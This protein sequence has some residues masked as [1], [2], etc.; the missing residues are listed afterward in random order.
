MEKLLS[1]VAEA[2]TPKNKERDNLRKFANKVVKLIN[3]HG[4]AA[5]IEGSLAKDTWISGNHDI[6]IFVFFEKST[7][8]ELFEKE[9]VE[10]GKK[11]IKELGG[12]AELAYS[13]HP[14]TRAQIKGVNLD[15]VPAYRLERV[16]DR[17]SAVDRTPFHTKYVSEH[18]TQYQKREVR[19]LKQFTKG[20][21]VYSAKEKVRG[22]SGYLC[23]LLVLNYGSLKGVA[24]AAVN[25]W[26]YGLV[27]DLEK[28]HKNRRDAFKKFQDALI[29]IDPTDMN[30]NVAAALDENNFEIFI[31]AF[32]NFLKKPTIQFFF[33]NLVEPYSET[34]LAQEMAKHG[35]I[36]I[37][38][39]K[40]P[41]IQED[42]LYSQLRKTRKNLRK[43]FEHFDFKVVQT[44]AL[45]NEETYIVIELENTTLPEIKLLEGPPIK[46]DKKYQDAFVEKY[47]KLKPWVKNKRWQVNV[48]RRYTRAED[49]FK[50]VINEPEKHG[51]PKYVIKSMSKK[52]TILTGATI[53]NEYTGEFARFLTRYLSNK[54]PWEW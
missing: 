18:L 43:A 24:K 41:K 44:D 4:Y 16:E 19:L 47:K 7:N 14:Y 50:H 36:F 6:D 31:Q 51:L 37:L 54:Q 21:G 15:I 30:R 1:E 3:K 34:E 38:K 39:F 28:H 40:T 8:R 22:F 42:I 52:H 12:T 27:I 9:G 25:K 45:S 10:V 32:K 20:V 33:P 53:L 49:L 35:E 23:E 17:G 26:E 5:S 46:V 48:P 2:I 13:E 11:V 29:V